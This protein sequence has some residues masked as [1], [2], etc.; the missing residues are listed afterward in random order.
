M[1]NPNKKVPN[2]KYRS[3]LASLFHKTQQMPILEHFF[4]SRRNT[5]W[6]LFVLPSP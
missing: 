2:Y 5:I 4:L 1:W 3:L 6:K